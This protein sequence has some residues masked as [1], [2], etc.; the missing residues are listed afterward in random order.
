MPYDR[1]AIFEQ[2]KSVA[3][4]KKLIWIEEVVA[5]LPISLAT[6]YVYFPVNSEELEAIKE[7]IANNRI[8]LKAAM[9]KKWYDSENPTL[10]VSLMKLLGTE[11]E[12]HRLNGSKTETKTEISSKDFD[13][14]QVF[15]IKSK[16]E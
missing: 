2:A 6:F 16:D 10:Q 14:S 12:T 8:S 11:E 9:R 13:L 1:N 3:E 5:F 4:S 7:I 15:R